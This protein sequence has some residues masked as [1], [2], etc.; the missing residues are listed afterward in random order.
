MSVAGKATVARRPVLAALLGLAGITLAAIATFEAPRLLAP[1]YAPS[2]FD[3][4]LAKLPD[5]DSAAR[6]GAAFL[7]ENRTFDADRT[8]KALR[9]SL[10]SR[11]LDAAMDSDLGQ[12]RMTE[13][14]GWVLPETIVTLCALA[15]KTSA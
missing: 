2:P 10:A 5:R 9:A 12:M 15:A 3:D 14:H 8:A 6:L 4:L 11:T 13:A 7:A 1:R